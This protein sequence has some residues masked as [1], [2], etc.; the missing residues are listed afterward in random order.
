MTT[1]QKKYTQKIFA[2]LDILGFE[3]FVNESR[4][5]PELI[6]K[7]TNTLLRSKAVASSTGNAKLTVLKVDP[8]QYRHLTF[9]D[10]SVISGPYISHDDIDFLSGWIIVYQYLMLKEE[11]TFIRGAVVYGDIYEDNDVLFGPALI[12]AYHLERDKAL[13][14]RV[15]ID[16]SLLSKFTETELKR[17]F[18]QLM[19]QD[20]N[21][22][23]LDYL[24]ELFHYLVVAQN[25]K[26]IGERN[27]DFG[28]PVKLFEDHKEAIITQVQYAL[29]KNDKHESARILTKYV[30][31]SEYHNSIIHRLRMVINN[32]MTDNSI[33][34]DFFNDLFEFYKAKMSEIEYQPKYSAEEYPE[35]ADMLDILG[36]V[37]N[38]VLSKP[39]EKELEDNVTA[40]NDL[41][42]TT[43][44]ELSTL[45]IS[46]KKSMIDIDR[47]F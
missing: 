36:A 24:R 45:D 25:K 32:L 41:I 5:N 33:V 10:T 40:L 31:L 17:D 34:R 28:P 3:E 43:C 29:R 1:N 37:T 4:K 16:A 30:K 22:V 38:A 2:F 26:V 35:Q 15:L 23:Y 19:T 47:L 11:R 18:C 21:L 8:T 13:W 20:N 27:E 42:D 44:L 9:S 7:I 12:D 46:L 39:I 14:P 6:N